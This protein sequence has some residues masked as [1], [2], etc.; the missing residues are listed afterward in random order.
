M[1]LTS[2]S[3]KGVRMES[4]RKLKHHMWKWENCNYSCDFIYKNRYKGFWKKFQ[5]KKIRNDNKKELKQA[6]KEVE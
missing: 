1:V 6:I 3:L 2:N 4:K 5:V